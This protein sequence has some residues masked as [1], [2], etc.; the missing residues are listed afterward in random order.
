MPHSHRSLIVAIQMAACGGYAAMAAQ[1]LST[2]LRIMHDNATVSVFQGDRPLLQYR[3]ADVPFKPY[4]AR[5]F[6][7]RG[8]NVL[9]DSPHDH[10]HHHALMFAVKAD[11]I[12]FW[13]ESPEC[14][15]QMGR[16]LGGV[17]ATARNGRS[18]GTLTQHIDW[19][20]PRTNKVLLRERRTIEV[21]RHEDAGASLLTWH[22]RLEPPEGRDSVK[23]SG[24]HYFGLGMRFVQ[25]MDRGGRFFNS[26]GKE[27]KIVRGEERL[28]RAKWCAYTA[29]ADGKRVTVAVF[30]H[31]ENARHPATMFMMPKHFAYI[32]ATLNLWKQPL[33]IKGGE[34]LELRYGVALWDG[35]VK[36]EQVEALH[37]RWS[38]LS[39]A[40]PA[41]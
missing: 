28:V 2:P 29:L 20:A 18:Q 24:S 3:Y 10:Q 37:R 27:G 7:P 40:D 4:V 11:G 17:K 34:P 36:P 21:C 39:S 6:S 9:R 5:Y 25:S 12:D 33:T 41:K 22:T 15:R 8:I 31:P 32:S 26:S 16:S 1:P 13:S 14:G 38:R 30:D 35:D 19:I 23:L